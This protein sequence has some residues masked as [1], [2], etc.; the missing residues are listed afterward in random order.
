MS[1]LFDDKINQIFQNAIEMHGYNTQY[2]K[3]VSSSRPEL[4]HFNAMP[5]C[6]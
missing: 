6:L 1:E 3:V 2:A 4:G 5:L